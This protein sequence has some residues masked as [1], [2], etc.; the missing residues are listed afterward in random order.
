MFIYNKVR[1]PQAVLGLSLSKS[2]IP[3]RTMAENSNQMHILKK[4]FLQ[5]LESRSTPPLGCRPKSGKEI[6]KEDV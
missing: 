6:R 5:N 4:S 3:V 2:P 1:P